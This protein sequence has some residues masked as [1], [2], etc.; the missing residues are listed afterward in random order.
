MLMI[1]LF[2]SC[3]QI[4]PFEVD[5]QGSPVLLSLSLANEGDC[6]VDCIDLSA[7]DVMYYPISETKTGSAGPNSKE[8]SYTAYNTASKF[9]VEVF[10]EITAGSSSAKADIT[11]NIA[12][13]EILV[14]DVVSGNSAVHEVDLPE[15]WQACD[16]IPFSIYQEGLSNPISFS[17]SY[18]LIGV[19]ADECEI[20]TATAYAG[21]L[22]GENSGAPSAGF[23]NAWWYVFDIDGDEEQAVYANKNEMIGTATYS[24][25]D[26]TITIDLGDWSLQGE[27]E[28]VKWYSYPDGGLP[29]AGRPTPGKAPN[30]GNTLTISTNGDRFYAIHLD[31]EICE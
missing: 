7:E 29:T 8:V 23:N 5:E 25:V 4:E 15:G 24:S 31:V 3:N 11:I 28:S 27:E 30:K 17:N 19:C 10:Y 1:A 2:F 6:S 22:L 26:G 18:S 20:R 21:D 16:E 12:G 14:E 9:I 13:N